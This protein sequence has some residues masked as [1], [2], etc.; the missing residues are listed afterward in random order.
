MFPVG[1]ALDALAN[2]A[3]ATLSQDTIV[4]FLTSDV[5]KE[6]LTH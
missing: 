5:G 2:D 6:I 1:L 4:D 3:I